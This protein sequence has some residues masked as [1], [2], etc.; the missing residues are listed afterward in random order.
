MMTA[1]DTVVATSQDSGRVWWVRQGPES[2][3]TVWSC[4]GDD[5]M[6]LAVLV[7]EIKVTIFGTSETQRYKTFDE[8]AD[9]AKSHAVKDELYHP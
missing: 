6:T 9:A 1:A 2:D 5:V 3:F 4:I 8:A 7:N